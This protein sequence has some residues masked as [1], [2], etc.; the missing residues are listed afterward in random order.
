MVFYS[1]A[2]CALSTYLLHAL[3]AQTTISV[4]NPF[5]PWFFSLKVSRSGILAP[6]SVFCLDLTEFLVRHFFN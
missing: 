5:V 6:F 1:I 2:V 3:G 4:L